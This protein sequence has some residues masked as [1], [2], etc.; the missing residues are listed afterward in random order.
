MHAFSPVSVQVLLFFISDIMPQLGHP[1]LYTFFLSLRTRISI[2]KKD[3]FIL[4]NMPHCF[5]DTFFLGVVSFDW[6]APS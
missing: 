5:D 6:R 2:L 3:S 1:I 4:Y